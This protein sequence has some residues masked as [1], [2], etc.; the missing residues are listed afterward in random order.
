M[1]SYLRNRMCQESEKNCLGKSRNFERELSPMRSQFRV[2][3]F[4]Q[5]KT[6]N[7]LKTIDTIHRKGKAEQIFDI[8]FIAV[9]LNTLSSHIR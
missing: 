6:F 5:T 2:T 4:T 7:E 1:P 3:R 8:S 9:M